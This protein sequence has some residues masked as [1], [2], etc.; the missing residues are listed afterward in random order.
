MHHSAVIRSEVDSAP[1]GTSVGLRQ[2]C[3]LA[4]SLINVC[5]DSAICQL[6]PQLQRLGVTRRPA[7]ALQEAHR[8]GADVHSDVC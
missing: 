2:G 7:H 3:V 1:F 5:L 6:L 8:G 4:P